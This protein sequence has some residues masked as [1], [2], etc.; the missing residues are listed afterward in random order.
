MVVVAIEMGAR[1][2]EFLL[3][4]MK[5]W[6]RRIVY[7]LLIALWLLLMLF[8]FTAFILATRGEIQSGSA[9]GT[10]VRIFLLQESEEKGVGLEWSRSAK[11]E[12]RCYRS[13]VFYFLWEG[14]AENV[15]YCQCFDAVTGEGLPTRPASCKPG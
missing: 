11:Q 12:E 4:P 9:P 5:R 13:R 7:A 2:G 15:T 1:P 14:E 10:H 3:S 6:L 8:P